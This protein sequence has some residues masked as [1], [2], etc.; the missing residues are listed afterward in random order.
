MIEFLEEI[1]FTYIS[2]EFQV[3]IRFSGEPVTQCSHQS[4]VNENHM[5]M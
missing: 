1:D 4:R 2:F 5:R 3:R